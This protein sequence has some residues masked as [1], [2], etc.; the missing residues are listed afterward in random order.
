MSAVK[1]GEGHV[2][3]SRRT[4]VETRFTYGTFFL[5]FNVDEEPALHK[6]LHSKFKNVFS[7]RASD[8]LEGHA[9]PLAESIRLFL[10]ERAAYQA[11][12]VWLQTMPRMLGYGFNPVSFWILKRQG[13]T[14]AVLVEVNNTFGQRH[15]YWIHPEGTLEGVWH[16]A[17]K[18]FHVSP[19]Q[20]TEGSYEFRFQFSERSSAVDINYRG[21]N[22]EMRLIT[23]IKGELTDLPAKSLRSL[24]WRYGWMT[25]LVVLRIH[26]QAL[27]LWFKKVPYVPKPPLPREELTR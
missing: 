10:K 2:F 17:Q 27:V 9:R 21:Q 11:E 23:W 12:E 19:F 18:V 26:Y 1:L 7:L 6:I 8:Y 20:P 3:H 14:E 22:G 5:H 4:D 25:P 16:K 13:K 24:I 15:F